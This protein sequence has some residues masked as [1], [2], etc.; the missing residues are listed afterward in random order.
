MKFTEFFWDFDGTLFDT[1]PR[2]NR[3]VQKSL[4]EMD[5]DVSL[6]GLLP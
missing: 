6:E 1:Y 4:H 5:I 3:A 2:I